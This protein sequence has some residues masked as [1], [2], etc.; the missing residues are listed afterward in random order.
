MNG[1]F[2]KLPKAKETK[3]KKNKT[4]SVDSQNINK[5]GN[6]LRMRSEEHEWLQETKISTVSCIVIKMKTKKNLRQF[7]K[8]SKCQISEAHLREDT[9]KGD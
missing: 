5:R 2:F 9:V 8:D 6:I 3:E 7:K 4:N 1:K